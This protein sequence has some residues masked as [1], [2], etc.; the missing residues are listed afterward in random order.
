MVSEQGHVDAPHT[1]VEPYI[2]PPLPP[3]TDFD[4]SGMMT[5]AST[6]LRSAQTLSSNFTATTVVMAVPSINQGYLPSS[7]SIP[8]MGNNAHHST[9]LPN[10]IYSMSQPFTVASQQP[11]YNL[12]NP[13]SNSNISQ[14]SFQNPYHLFPNDFSISKLITLEL[15]NSN[16][17]L[18]SSTFLNALEARNKSGFVDGTLKVPD[19]SDPIFPFWRQSNSLIKT[20]LTNSISPS[21]LQS[22][23]TWKSA[24]EI[25]LDLKSI[26]S[27]ANATR[28][29]EVVREI[30]NI[31]QGAMNV[32]DYYSKIKSLWDEL[33]RNKVLPRCKC[34]KCICDVHKPFLIDREKDKV[35]QFLMGLNDSYSN[36]SSQI[37][38]KEPF[39]DVGRLL[40]WLGKKKESK[41]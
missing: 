21:I 35:M 2:D 12:Q 38:L 34:G 24:R 4:A 13:Y 15:N 8:T 19:E 11:S 39:P 28:V 31:R 17:H 30:S 41:G 26:Y 25:W 16:Y 6:M 27:V 14:N 5:D 37:L 9:F 33:E 36:V 3:I 18:R 40:I 20:W 22:V 29:F 10:P 1:P 32:T 7:L 23:S